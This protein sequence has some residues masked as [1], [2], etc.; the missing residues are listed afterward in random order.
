MSNENRIT[1]PLPPFPL[2]FLRS[3]LNGG[4]LR[5]A[6][7]LLR[8]NTLTQ[9]RQFAQVG[10]PAQ[11]NCLAKRALTSRFSPSQQINYCVTSDIYLPINDFT[12]D[13]SI[14]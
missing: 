1:Y 11:H 5:N 12:F 8:K 10:E 2:T 3:L 7:R 4:N 9:P 6:R 13:L 14:Q